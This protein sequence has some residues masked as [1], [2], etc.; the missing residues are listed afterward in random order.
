MDANT[1]KLHEEPIPRP[2]RFASPLRTVLHVLVSLAAWVLFVYWWILVLR[3]VSRHIVV[4]TALLMLIALVVVVLLTLAWSWHNREI[5]QRKGPRTHVREVEE[6]FSRDVVG[7]EVAFE[8]TRE[9]MRAERE[10]YVVFD[11]TLKTYK[12]RDASAG[13][14]G[15]GA[16]DAS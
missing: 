5:H 12:A 15:E 16:G 8:G 3:D 2:P 1:I 7:R 14:A 11:E 6:D 10:V 4:I 13:R 9:R